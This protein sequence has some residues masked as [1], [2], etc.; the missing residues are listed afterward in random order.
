MGLPSRTNAFSAPLTWSPSSW[1]LKKRCKSIAFPLISSGTYGYP[2]DAALQV[3]TSVIKDFLTNHDMDIFL[4]IFD[5][6]S[7]IISEKLLG[8]VESYIDENY[9][10]AHLTHSQTLRNSEC[11]MLPLRWRCLTKNR[12]K[13]PPGVWTP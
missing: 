4:V 13:R 2:K 5:Q 9:V 3:A 10:A 7:F 8:A 1:P 12:C 11:R 6:G